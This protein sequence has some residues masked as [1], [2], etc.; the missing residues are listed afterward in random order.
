MVKA[1][2]EEFDGDLF[3]S[4]FVDGLHNLPVA[5]IPKVTNDVKFVSYFRPFGI[6]GN[7]GLLQFR[8]IQV[9]VVTVH[10]GGLCI[11]TLLGGAVGVQGFTVKQSGHGLERTT[12]WCT[13]LG[14]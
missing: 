11:L 3:S 2:L 13:L 1:V 7:S 8:L 4:G 10:P 9:I 6:K 12:N 5:A 14:K